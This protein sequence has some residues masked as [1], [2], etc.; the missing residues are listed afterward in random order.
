MGVSLAV[1]VL[2]NIK[3]ILDNARFFCLDLLRPLNILR[4]II[5]NFLAVS[6]LKL[7][8]FRILQLALHF[9]SRH[10]TL[11]ISGVGLP[12]LLPY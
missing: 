12:L 1:G 7:K 4:L 8:S 6:P 5:R 11:L 3:L 2:I 9:K 10:E